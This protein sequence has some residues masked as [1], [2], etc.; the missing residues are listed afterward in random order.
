VG[1]LDAHREG[2]YLRHMRLGEINVHVSTVG[3]AINLEN[4]VAAVP[5]FVRQRKLSTWPRFIS[6]IEYH[7]T[8]SLTKSTATSGLAKIKER[9]GL[10]SSRKAPTHRRGESDDSTVDA[11]KASLLLGGKRLGR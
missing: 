5:A 6:K 1:D 4:Y 3:F 10:K 9:F 8:W 2:V 7:A 11:S